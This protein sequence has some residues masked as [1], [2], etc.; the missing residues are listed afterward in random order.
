MQ[1]SISDLVYINEAA[2]CLKHRRFAFI[3]N[4]LIGLD[5]IQT[6][7]CKIVLDPNKLENVSLKGLIFDQRDLSKF[8]KALT[9]ESYFYIDENNAVNQMFTNIGAVEMLVLT[10]KNMI[11]FALSRINQSNLIDSSIA[12]YNNPISGDITK[13]IEEVF[14]MHKGD[15]AFYYK[16]QN[17]YYLTLFNGLLPLNKS[18][19]V[20]L[21]ILDNGMEPTFTAKYDIKKSKF[22][23]SIYI[24]YL[25]VF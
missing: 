8:I 18:D 5:N 22:V 3:N 13:D 20:Y 4:L 6:Y 19:K 12:A 25:K 23:I 11:D 10:D 2:K 21:S 1:L 15:G 14:T 24:A 16:F 9:T 7:I 17:R